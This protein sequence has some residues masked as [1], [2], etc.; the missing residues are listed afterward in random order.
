MTRARAS[1]CLCAAVAAVVSACTGDARRA[2]S[3][4]VPSVRIG[5]F[6]ESRVQWL[7]GMLV[8][9]AIGVGGLGRPPAEPPG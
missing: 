3:A 6:V 8:C 5:T 9:G 2:D 4:A 1:A 7:A